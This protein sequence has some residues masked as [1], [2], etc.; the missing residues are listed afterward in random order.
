MTEAITPPPT[1][2][3]GEGV[4]LLKWLVPNY[5]SIRKTTKNRLTH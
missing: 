4:K 2:K 3:E 5:P 1:E